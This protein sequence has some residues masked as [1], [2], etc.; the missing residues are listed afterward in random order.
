MCFLNFFFI[1]TCRIKFLHWYILSK[2]KFNMRR[3]GVK[4]VFAYNRSFAQRPKFCRC[5]QT[6]NMAKI[7][8]SEVSR[9]GM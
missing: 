6:A 2:I 3:I 4:Q 1:I 5:T 7:H 8:G 9:T